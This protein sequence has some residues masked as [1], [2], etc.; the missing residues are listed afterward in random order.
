M[1]PRWRRA[2]GLG[3]LG[4]VCLPAPAQTPPFVRSYAEL[5]SASASGFGWQGVG[6]MCSQG[7]LG[8]TAAEAACGYFV[9]ATGWSFNGEARCETAYGR[10]RVDVTGSA[11]PPADRNG[12]GVN[13]EWRDIWTIGGHTGSG[14]VTVSFERQ[15]V[16]SGNPSTI[17]YTLQ[18]LVEGAQHL[19][20]LTAPPVPPEG[21]LTVPAVGFTFGVTPIHVAAT[22]GTWGVNDTR[23]LAELNW[24][25]FIPALTRSVA[26][27]SLVRIGAIRV[28]KFNEAAQEW[29]PV[30]DFTLTA[31]S[32]TDPRCVACPADVNCS[33][34][35][36]VQD[37]FDFLAA[38]FAGEPAGDF[39]G[40]GGWSVQDI[41]DFL[42]AYFAGC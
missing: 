16:L 2:A 10:S 23:M 27:T 39:N 11:W 31:A 17:S 24:Q 13:S 9:P 22:Q 40:V 18:L 7:G 32:G 20:Q 33:H 37:I 3:V 30:T 34:D 1:R 14:R 41:F 42:A 15:F 21:T 8:F 6:P 4:A 19:E 38:Y 28:E 5:K 25:P 35:L 12:L 36:T 26:L 29:E